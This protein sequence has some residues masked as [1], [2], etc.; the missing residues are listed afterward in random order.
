MPHMLM[1]DES[2]MAAIAWAGKTPW[3]KLGQEMSELMTSQEAL[4]NA[5]LDWQVRLEQNYVCIDG[6][7]IEVPNTFSTVRNQQEGDDSIVL[8][9]NGKTVTSRYTPWQNVEALSFLDDLVNTGEA[10]IEVAGAL[11]EGQRIWVLARLPSYIKVADSD[12]VM[13]YVLISNNH[14]G[15]GSIRIQ[16]TMIRVVCNNTLTMALGSDKN[17]FVMRHTA[18][19]NNRVDEAREILGLVNIRLGEWSASAE[20]MLR[21]KMTIEEMREYWEDSMGLKRNELGELSTRAE[22]IIKEIEACRTH[23]TNMVGDMDMTAWQAY[24]A[25][26]YY[27][28]HINTLDNLGFQDNNKVTSA[29]MGNNSERKVKG[30]ELM[31]EK[32]MEVSK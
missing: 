25:L 8:S 7:F 30:W 17:R 32:M 4:V 28:D 18:N 13:N 26:T 6:E 16:P 29:L 15:T 19:V 10:V 14:D 3:H 5:R 24:N 12:D 27:I 21:V 23:E 20:E 22:N 2:G 31:E 9:K 11:D 1:E